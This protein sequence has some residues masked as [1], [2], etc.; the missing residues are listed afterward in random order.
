MAWRSANARQK[1]SGLKKNKE[2]ERN[3]EMELSQI[4][5]A[6]RVFNNITKFQYVV[7]S[8]PLLDKD[9]H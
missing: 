9:K 8:K 7:F 5:K 2:T 6:K 1:A 3:R 4:A